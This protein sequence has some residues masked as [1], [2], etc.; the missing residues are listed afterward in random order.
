MQ[1][2]SLKTRWLQQ[3]GDNLIQIDCK[4]GKGYLEHRGNRQEL[5]FRRFCI[6]SEGRM[7]VE[8]DAEEFYFAVTPL[9]NIAAGISAGC[10]SISRARRIRSSPRAR[11][12]R[13]I[14]PLR[15]PRGPALPRPGLLFKKARPLIFTRRRRFSGFMSGAAPCGT[16]SFCILTTTI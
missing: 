14:T 6:W 4:N 7:Y 11:W 5:V 9:Q 15:K 1:Y 16:A 2:F 3:W 13:P 10:A 12:S 8:A